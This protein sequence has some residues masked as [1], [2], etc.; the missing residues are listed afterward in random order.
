MAVMKPVPN[1]CCMISLHLIVVGRFVFAVVDHAAI[2][3]GLAAI[4]LGRMIVLN[5]VIVLAVH[6]DATS[7]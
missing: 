2:A 4:V 6:F 1:L 3:V 7:E 5:H